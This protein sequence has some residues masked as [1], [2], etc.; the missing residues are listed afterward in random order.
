MKIQESKQKSEKLKSQEISDATKD[1]LQ[2]NVE[3][4]KVEVAAHLKELRTNMTETSREALKYLKPVKSGKLS[5]TTTEATTT[6]LETTTVNEQTT[7]SF[8]S[9]SDMTALQEV[10]KMPAFLEAMRLKFQGNPRNNRMEI[11]QLP[12]MS[13]NQPINQNFPPNQPFFNSLNSNPFNMNP[14]FIHQNSIQNLPFQNFN[15]NQN[16][17]SNFNQFQQFPNQQNLFNPNL[18]QFENFIANPKKNE[19]LQVENLNGNGSNFQKLE[20]LEDPK[21]SVE[22]TTKT[23]KVKE[24]QVE[25]EV[26]IAG[27]GSDEKENEDFDELENSNQPGGGGL[28]GLIAGLSGVS[29]LKN[30]INSIFIKTSFI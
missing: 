4:L 22:T 25:I 19:K 12:L 21:T 20:N 7:R 11:I 18:N 30:L 8:L 26:N 17:L 29:C 9:S 5:A 13:H 1:D 23:D 10:V 3:M 27:A 14:N 24:N 15:P 16:F 2:K 28:V 6:T